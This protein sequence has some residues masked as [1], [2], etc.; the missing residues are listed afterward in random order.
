MSGLTRGGDTPGARFFMCYIAIE[1]VVMATHAWALFL[2]SLAPST[3]VGV[4]L[5]P[6]SIMPMAVLSGFFVNQQD[7]SWVFRWFSYI[8]Y[9]NYGW[10]AMAT[11]GFHGLT[12]NVSEDAGPGLQT[13]EQV[14]KNRLR[15]ATGSDLSSFWVNIGV[16]VST[17]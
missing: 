11:A 10:Q 1:L 12:F 4:L 8:D 7:M 13:G 17:Q 15:L 3:E 6:G 14:L 16:L 9:L 5:A 2:C